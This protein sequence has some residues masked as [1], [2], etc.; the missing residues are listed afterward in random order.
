MLY[1]YLVKFNSLYFYPHYTV[2]LSEFSRIIQFYPNNQNRKNK[3][4]TH[5]RTH[6]HR[7]LP[8]T[9]YINK[10][11]LHSALALGSL[12]LSVIF[13]EENEN[14]VSGMR[15]LFVIAVIF[16]LISSGLIYA[17]IAAT[18]PEQTKDAEVRTI[19]IP[20]H[21]LDNPLPFPNP[22]QKQPKSKAVVE[23]T[24]QRYDHFVLTNS[25]A[26]NAIIALVCLVYHL[27]KNN[28]LVLIWY[29]AFTAITMFTSP[30]FTV[31]MLRQRLSRPFRIPDL[32]DDINEIKRAFQGLQ[33]EMKKEL[34]AMGDDIN[35]PKKA[36]KK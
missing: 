3:N 22:L 30:L 1:I 20:Q 34:E 19:S 8:F 2:P 36:G 35:G 23:V 13:S 18:P 5:P 15:Y 10:I 33:K 27:A 26:A 21:E 9:M 6:P 31:H 17:S 11:Y 12:I 28:L 7:T 16:Q 32:K 4:H 14:Y 29:A 25:F 24:S